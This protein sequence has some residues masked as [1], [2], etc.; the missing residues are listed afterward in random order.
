MTQQ[1]KCATRENAEFYIFNPFALI[2]WLLYKPEFTR[3]LLPSR[4]NWIV[5]IEDNNG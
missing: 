5:A 4:P 3:Q 2:G 1:Q